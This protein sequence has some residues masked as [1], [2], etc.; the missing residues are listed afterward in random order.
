MQTRAAGSGSHCGPL[1]RAVALA[2]QQGLHPA[3]SVVGT[4][5][6]W[7]QCGVYMDSRCHGWI[8]S[9]VRQPE[10]TTPPAAAA[11]A[12]APAPGACRICQ[13]ARA[14]CSVSSSRAVSLFCQQQQWYKQQGTAL[15]CIRK[16]ARLANTG[17]GAAL[18]LHSHPRTSIH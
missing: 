15:S 4:E 11:I 9:S 7:Q 1:E 10:I 8:S 6:G 2:K 16:C 17:V 3:L 12:A 5:C 14:V 18:Y 13:A